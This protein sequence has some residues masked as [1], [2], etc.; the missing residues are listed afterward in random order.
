MKINSTLAASTRRV[1]EV[2]E[3]AEPVR[4]DVVRVVIVVL[5][6]CNLFVVSLTD[7]SERGLLGECTDRAVLVLVSETL[8]AEAVVRGFIGAV[9]V[10]VRGETFVI[11]AL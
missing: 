10:V 9:A 6:T 1:V 4:G 3:I 8:G 7:L 11:G 5:E 2:D